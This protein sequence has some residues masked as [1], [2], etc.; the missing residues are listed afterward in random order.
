M[1]EISR[2]QGIKEEIT[3][4]TARKTNIFKVIPMAASLSTTQRKIG[5]GGG[6]YSRNV[7]Y[8]AS[9]NDIM[10]NNFVTGITRQN[11][12]K[13]FKAVATYGWPESVYLQ[14]N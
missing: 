1:S 10:M 7:S 4:L 13:M 9:I 11:G 2:G 8:L 14:C 12:M 6:S 3:K 5:G